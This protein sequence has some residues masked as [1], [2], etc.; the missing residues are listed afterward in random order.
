MGDVIADPTDAG[1]DRPNLPTIEAEG[2]FFTPVPVPPIVCEIRLPENVLPSN[3][4][5][6]WSLFF[7]PEQLQII[8]NHTNLHALKK[9][10]RG[11]AVQVQCRVWT[12]VTV[13]ELYA[14]F[15]IRIY[16]G[17]N[18]QPRVRDYWN[19]DISKPLHPIIRKAMAWN[20]YEA[21]DRMLYLANPGPNCT[22]FDKVSAPNTSHYMYII[23]AIR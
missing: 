7:P 5:A 15:G 1:T 11:Q 9:E 16:M 14:Y 20:R 23:L 19:T 10:E 8:A 21:I 2:T 3:P 18:R 13:Q 6:I 17:I 12:D 4:L 22:V